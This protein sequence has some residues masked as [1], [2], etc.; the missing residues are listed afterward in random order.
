VSSLIEKLK[1]GTDNT[2]LINWP[3]SEQKVLLRILSQKDIQD[4]SFAAERLF[5][6]EK[7][8]TN[9]MTA[10]TYEEE[11]ATQLLFKSL[12]D[13]ERQDEPIATNITEF[14]KALTKEEKT[15]LVG[16][17]MTFE[18][19]CSPNPDN[20]SDEEFD[21]VLQ[22]VKK[23]PASIDS[24]NCSSSLLRRFITILA[25]PPQRLPTDNS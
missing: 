13:P 17:Y 7:I 23:N 24:L 21:K 19:D 15:Q 3:G 1:L 8:E 9:M 2:K 5:K 6:A 16:E 12:R 22:D 25:S 11:Q 18:R 4:A 20:M 10:T 14:R